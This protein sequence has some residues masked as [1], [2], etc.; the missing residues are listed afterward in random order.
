MA[1]LDG[2]LAD[3]ETPIK[4]LWQSMVE[5]PHVRHKKNEDG[6][7]EL[8]PKEQWK[9]HTV[10]G[11]A[12]QDMKDR[13]DEEAGSVL[14]TAK[15]N[16]SLY[17]DPVIDENSMSS[18]FVI[19]DLMNHEQPV[20]LYIITLPPD[21][22]RMKPLIRL[23]VTM[24][25]RV[26]ASS[27]IFEKD[28]RKGYNLG[29]KIIRILTGKSIRPT[30]GGRR[31]RGNYK[32]KQLLM[33]DEF[34]SLGKLAI[35]QG[36]L[37]F[38]AGYGMKFYGICQDKNQLTDR[39]KGYGPDESITSNCHIQIAYAP[40]RPETAELLSKMT[41]QTTIIK[42][43]I[44]ASG[45]VFGAVLSNVS[46]SYQEVQRALLTP[47]E[48]MRMPGP[49]KD[50]SGSMIK[51][52]GDMIVFVAGF[53][54]IYGKQPLYFQDE[55]LTARSELDPPEKTDVTRVSEP[56]INYIIKAAETP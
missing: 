22:D 31:A 10:V 27:M 11:R 12:A 35:L 38:I 52:A 18:D 32:H 19:H 4:E 25:V 45:K 3:T 40:N 47:D 42:E 48:C 54:P 49:K 43:Q 56:D 46:R 1:A 28:K 5:Y 30:G 50:A 21:K 44:S 33:I 8:L 39:E 24:I 53:H 41:G 6:T 16:L 36:S 34:P 26:Q 20:S 2:L 17:R 15:S 13:P 55:V 7:E 23:L 14:S 37:A 29:Q 9:T 51:E